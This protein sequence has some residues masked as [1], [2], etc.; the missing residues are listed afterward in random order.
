M[1]QGFLAGVLWGGVAGAALLTVSTQ[2]I[3][4][5]DAGALDPVEPGPPE[6]SAVEV[7]AGTEFDQAREASDP[8]IPAEETRPGGEAVSDVTPPP[9]LGTTPPAFD[10]SALEM[11]QPAT[12]PGGLGEVPTPAEEVRVD[13][14]GPGEGAPQ[15]AP[16][17]PLG[18]PDSASAPVT[19]TDAPEIAA[20]D[21][22]EAPETPA[23]TDD[24]VTPEDTE[25]AP[26]MAEAPGSVAP[27]TPDISPEAPTA[28]D[29]PAAMDAPQVPQGSDAP[30]VGGES[31]PARPSV[32]PAPAQP[33]IAPA[34]APA[35][36]EAPAPAPV[37]LAEAGDSAPLAPAEAPASAEVDPVEA[38]DTETDRGPEA[39][40]E[41][42]STS[43][44]S[45]P[46]EAPSAEDGTEVEAPSE[47]EPAPSPAPVE[48]ASDAEPAPEPET[49]AA[50]VAQAEAP[51][52]RPAPGEGSGLPRVIRLVGD[53]TA[54]VAEAEPKDDVA[55]A[56]PVDPGAPAIE[57]FR[58]PVDLG[59]GDAIL[60]LVV[61]HEGGPPD[62]GLVATLPRGLAFAVDAGTPE[63][64]TVAR[65]YRAAGRE[66]VMIPDLPERARPQD[67]EQAMQA[68]L[69]AV[70]EAVAVMDTTGGG[71]QSDREAVAQVVDAI[72][73]TGHGLITFPRGLNTAHQRAEREGVPR[74]LIF[75]DIDGGGESDAEIGRSLDRAAFRARQSR[76]PV[77]LV[78]RATDGTL[79]AVQ[80]WAAQNAGGGVVLAPV[81][82][83]L[84]AAN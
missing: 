82:A 47:V 56:A 22:G 33:V 43:E 76:Q 11:P 23:P 12:A 38:G 25:T 63:A 69:R 74:G 64:E 20:P 3:L 41:T 61:L 37:E 72:G 75:R 48:V 40:V 34:T 36:V 67:V 71:F 45:V 80:A 16:A 58:V 13:V 59:L 50:P 60:S 6:A 8:E 18:T 55:E 78:G 15:I 53:D 79:Q 77:I 1:A 54:T 68:N 83:A 35:P 17:Q 26:G 81:S 32:E 9:D 46:D 27:A 70:P 84:L 24:G 44:T 42:P 29:V 5:Q 65:A 19:G 51:R 39:P 49:D 28:V 30:A 73:A 52:V 31:Q 10:T 66:V 57:R 2:V 7:P 21:A 14:T 4:R 62:L